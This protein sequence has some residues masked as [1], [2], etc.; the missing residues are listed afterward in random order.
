VTSPRDHVGQAKEAIVREWDAWIRT[1]LL[2]GIAS[3]RDAR[4]FFLELKAGRSPT[5][6]DF[7]SDAQDKWRV[8]RDWLLDEQRFAD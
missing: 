4:R 1:Q 3:T 2:N 7:R 8:V 5:L 6:L